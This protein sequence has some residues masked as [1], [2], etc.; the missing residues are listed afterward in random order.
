MPMAFAQPGSVW[1]ALSYGKM[2]P[3]LERQACCRRLCP[4]GPQLWYRFAAQGPKSSCLFPLQGVNC[5][6]V[7]ACQSSMQ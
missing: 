3:K 4:P 5:V 1:C 2:L 7:P 6:L